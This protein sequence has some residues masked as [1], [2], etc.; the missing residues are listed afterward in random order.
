[1]KPFKYFLFSTFL[2]LTTFGYS[3]KREGTL[4]PEMVENATKRKQVVGSYSSYVTK[5]GTILKIGDKITLGV[6]S[7]NKSFAF[8]FVGINPT[9]ANIAVSGFDFEIT[10]IQCD[11]HQNF[12]FFCRFKY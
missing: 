4:T 11:G 5:D 10:K 3:Q 1:M 9:N 7:S 2:L 6:P 12:G 8:V